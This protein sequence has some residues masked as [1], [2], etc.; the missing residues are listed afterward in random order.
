MD[1]SKIKNLIVLSLAVFAA[2]YLGI[3]AATAQMEV[4]LWVVGGLGLTVCLAMGRRIWLMLPFMTSL[5]LVLPIQGNFSTMLIAQ[6]LILGFCSMLFL[7][8]K[9]PMLFRFTEL[10]FWNLLF[11]L[12]VAQV[13]MRNPIGLNLF[14]GDSIGGKPY[15]MFI[16]TVATA[17]L[18]SVLTVPPNELKW[19]VRATMLGSWINFGLGAVAKMVPSVGTYLGASFSTDVS[20]DAGLADRVAADEGA[21]SRVSFVRQISLDLAIWV[22]SKVSPLKACVLPLW[23]P[24][25]A[26]TLIAAA[27]SGFRSQFAAV[28]LTY[29]VGIL[30]RGGLRHLLVAGILVAAGLTV[31]GLGNLVAPLPPNIQRSLSFLPGTWEERYTRD[32]AESTEWRMQMWIDAL[33]SDRYIKNRIMGDGLGMTADQLR[34]ATSEATSVGNIDA[35]RESAMQAGDYHSGPVQTI[36]TVGYVGLVVLLIGLVRLGVHTHRQIERCRNT[37]WFSTALFIGNTYV[38][39][40][41]GWTLI[42]G[43]FLGGAS[44]LFMGSALVRLLQNNLPLPPYVVKRREPYILKSSRQRLT[45]AD[46]NP[47][48]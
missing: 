25:V 39:F 1:S 23:A 42:F 4:V 28:A 30:Y 37:E 33:S 32:T 22:S 6:F 13:Y 48:G 11:L 41:F 38:W 34:L 17:L 12:C 43:S 19:Y 8:R 10:E 26:F 3:A 5:S 35:H 44:A 29:L 27:V 24:L 31:L 7:M 40:A 18:V 47:R 36:R 21:A 15:V 46:S 45:E 2:L 9:L 14:G 16:I 20:R